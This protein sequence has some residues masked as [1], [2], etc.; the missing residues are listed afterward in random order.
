[1]QASI[2]KKE[3]VRETETESTNMFSAPLM[4]M[5]CAIP[6]VYLLSK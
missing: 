2:E 6:V 5:I 3:Y 4:A 1:V